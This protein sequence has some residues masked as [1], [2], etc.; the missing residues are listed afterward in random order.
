MDA[1][2]QV[3]AAAWAIVDDMEFHWDT[4]RWWYAV[5]LTVLISAALGFGS[6]ASH[7]YIEFA[8]PDLAI[9]PVSGGDGRGEPERIRLPSGAVVFSNHHAVLAKREELVAGQADF[10]FVDL[11]A[12]TLTAYEGG[13]AARLFPLRAKGREGSF[14]E[15]PNGIY[16]L[17]A[18]EANHFSSIGKVW[19]PWSM[20]FFGNYFIHGWPYY[21]NGTPVAETF[22]GGCIRL[23]SDDAKAVFERSRPGMPLLVAAGVERP[24]ADFAYFRKVNGPPREHP[25]L[26]LSAA[27]ALAADLETGQ[28]LFEK[29][30]SRVHPVASVTKLMTGLVALE[31][32]N[33]FKLLTVTGEA[34][35][36]FG[37]S[38]G[39][40]AGE[41]FRSEDLLYP[42]ILVS[43]NDAAAVYEQQSWRL[44][45]AMNEKANAIGLTRT[46]FVD[47]SGMSAGNVSTTED[48]FRLLRYISRHKKPLFDLSGLAEYTLASQNVRRVHHWTNLNW[49]NGDSRFIGG[50]SGFTRDALETMAGVFNVRFSEYGDRPVAMVVLGSRDRLGDVRDLIGYLEEQFVYGATLTK[51]KPR[52]DAIPAGASLYEAV[53]LLPIVD[54]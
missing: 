46:Y 29:E 44:V 49:P 40:V 5:K 53:R 34:V 30:R 31:T 3:P 51:G 14:F 50:K 9:V 36:A 41:A 22:S 52:P 32:I 54:E 24:A 12:M 23:A 39:F 47:A 17:Q 48:L 43:S 6:L 19:M 33:R 38:A 8:Q 25:Q 42:L 35:E 28:I 26:S 7:Q 27:S 18:K 1:V 15:T 13:R 2:V 21:P 45:G 10:L 16:Y 4:E 11:G 37:D 20:H